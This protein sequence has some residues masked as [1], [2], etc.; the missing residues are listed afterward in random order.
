MRLG[1]H[2][3]A[4]L[5]CASL[6]RGSCVHSSCLGASQ[7][8]AKQG[9]TLQGLGASQPLAVATGGQGDTTTLAICC[10]YICKGRTPVSEH[11]CVY[12]ECTK[13]DQGWTPDRALK[14]QCVTPG[15]TP[16]LPV[17][18]ISA[19]LDR[20]FTNAPGLLHYLPLPFWPVPSNTQYERSSPVEYH[21]TCAVRS[22]PASMSSIA[23]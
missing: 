19:A 1:N 11:P 23:I 17:R 14:F 2:L 6:T 7:T 12:E 10:L 22:I 4:A 20:F 13:P 16:T 9:D 3:N 18:F 5:A 21:L 8:S 15:T